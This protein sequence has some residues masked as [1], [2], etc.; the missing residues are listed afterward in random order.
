MSEI[1]NTGNPGN[2]TDAEW[3]DYLQQ[4]SIEMGLK[5][6]A[7]LAEYNSQKFNPATAEIIPEDTS[8]RTRF[9][10]PG[11]KCGRG[12]VR[13]ISGRQLNYMRMLLNT[14]N[15]RKIMDEKWFRNLGATSHQTLLEAVEFISLA[16]ART[17]ITALL[18]CPLRAA[19]AEAAQ[20]IEMATTPQMN[21][22]STL[23]GQKE[24]SYGEV[25]VTDLTKDEARGMITE[26]KAAPFKAT[27]K[28]TKEE[29]VSV[30]GI[31]ELD[32][33]IF[34]MKK[35]RNGNHFYAMELTNEETGAWEYAA[36]MA[37]KVP[38]QGRKLSLEECESLSMKL[39]C[40]G[41]CDRTLTATVD[42]VGPAAR[43]IG[44]ICK[45]KMG[46]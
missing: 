3:L 26:L 14:R 41:I 43:F 38:A 30:I 12:Q 37:H 45:A 33:K 35:A 18:C 5:P 11:Q 15:Y 16:G 44:P 29:T 27:P 7:T 25:I 34:R 46:Y 8:E 32:G 13:K 23:L 2:M 22:L 31:Y 19:V 39:G 10:K 24:H 40:C 20:D 28:A 1:T 9:A 4:G 42:G 21:Y 6:K 17:M 36:G